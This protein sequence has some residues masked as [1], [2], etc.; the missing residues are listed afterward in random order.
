MHEA[1]LGFSPPAVPYGSLGLLVTVIPSPAP[2]LSL[3][4]LC[5][6]GGPRGQEGTLGCLALED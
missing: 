5:V 2:N 3:Q 1:R 4:G 6:A